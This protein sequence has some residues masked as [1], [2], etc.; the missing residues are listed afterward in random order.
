MAGFHSTMDKPECVSRVTP[1]NTTITKIMIAQINNQTA[2]ARES[3]LAFEEWVLF[4]GIIQTNQDEMNRAKI[5]FIVL[6]L[7]AELYRG[8]CKNTV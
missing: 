5:F 8:V 1:P 6:F 4:N 3:V 2:I 7:R